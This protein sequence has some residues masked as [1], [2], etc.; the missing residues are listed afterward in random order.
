MRSRYTAYALG[1]VEHPLSSW[2]PT[3]RPAE[4]TLDPDQRW[5]HLEILGTTGGRLLD[6]TGTVEFRAH[7]RSGGRRGEQ[8]E[9][10]RFVREQ[11]RWLYL[12]EV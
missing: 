6:D 1:R 12:T 7:Y 9:N 2:H 4:L 11:G 5:L 8:Q 3:T 10:S